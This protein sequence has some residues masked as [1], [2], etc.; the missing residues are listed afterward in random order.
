MI[1]GRFVMRDG[2]L[3]QVDLDELLARADAASDAVLG[4]IGV[5]L[6]DGREKG[7]RR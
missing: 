4:R 6:G 3:T 5:T 2:V 1:D 7:D